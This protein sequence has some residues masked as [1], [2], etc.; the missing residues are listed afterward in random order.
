MYY[1]TVFGVF[2][3][4]RGKIPFARSATS[5]MRSITSLRSTSFATCRNIVLCRKRTMMFS[6]RSKWCWPSVKWC[7]ALRHKWKNPESRAF[8]IFWRWRPDLNRRITVLQTGALPLGYVTKK[9]ERIT[10]LEPATSTLARSRSTK[11]ANSAKV[12][13]RRGLEPLT[14]SVT[15]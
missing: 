15:G 7:C 12:A 11:C 6:L 10:G 5:L 4:L 13:T 8:R 14:S 1:I 9:M 3:D 2:Q